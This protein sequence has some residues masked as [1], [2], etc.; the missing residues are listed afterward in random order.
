MSSGGQIKVITKREIDRE[1]SPWILGDWRPDLFSGSIV[2]NREDMWKDVLMEIMQCLAQ[3]ALSN[4]RCS[5]RYTTVCVIAEAWCG[6]ERSNM[7]ARY[8]FCFW[9]G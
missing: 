2:S 8:V 7:Q 5:L 1:M 4:D 9:R 6:L 3:P